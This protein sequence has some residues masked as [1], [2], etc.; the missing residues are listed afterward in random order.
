MDVVKSQD[1]QK[2][3]FEALD[4][5]GEYG[6]LLGT[7]EPATQ[8]HIW[9]AAGSGKSTYALQLARVLANETRVLY[10]S[11]EE[12]AKRLVAERLERLK[13][14]HPNL[15]ISDFSGMEALEKKI[16][17]LN[18]GFVIMDS[19]SV[20]GENALLFAR[21]MRQEGIGVV[22]IAH[23]TKMGQYKGK[24]DVVHEVD[25][26]LQVYQDEDGK[27]YAETQKN[28]YQPLSRIPVRFNGCDYG[29]TKTKMSRQNPVKV[30]FDHPI[31]VIAQGHKIT[32][33]G[34]LN[35]Y[36]G[37]ES[38]CT[39]IKDEPLAF[40]WQKTDDKLGRLIMLEKG[41]V[42]EEVCDVDFKTAWARMAKIRGG[43]TIR[44]KDQ[45]HAK[46]LL[47][48][49]GYIK[50][51]NQEKR[52]KAKKKAVDKLA[53]KYAIPK[54]MKPRKPAETKKK[55]S[56]KRKIASIKSKMSK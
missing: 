2:Q 20:I 22:F 41:R 11:A 30:P 21:K 28:R 39:N 25:I 55:T 47:G 3:E 10:V 1:L 18:I 17:E 50:R 6:E 19:V 12:G 24:T 54:G 33:A 7:I 46:A 48:G 29:K 56:V 15:Y 53:E 49:R 4:L 14:S 9:G 8:I 27:T 23:A 40:M 16:K 37:I 26:N 31:Y 44:V 38:G 5:H 34:M 32:S 52:A 45:Q 51:E 43:Y 13:A 35:R 36:L 42:I